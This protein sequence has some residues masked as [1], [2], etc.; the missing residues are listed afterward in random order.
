MKRLCV[1]LACLVFVGINLVQAQTVRITGTVKSSEDGMP[2]PGVSV[3]VKGTTTGAATNIDGVYELNVAANAQTLV[4]SSVGF[5]AQE[6]EIGGRSIIDITLESESLQVEE[7]VVTALGIKRSEKSLPYVSQEVK[8]EELNITSDANIK[9]AIV[10][11]VAGVQI[12]GQ[13]G[14]KLGESGRIRIRGAVSMTAD[15]DPLYVLD[16]VPVSDPNIIDME[17]VASVNVL[18]GPNATA[19]YGQRAE[20]GV[21]MITSKKATKGGIT[22]EVNNN[23]TFD[24]VAYLPNYQN[25]YGQG[26]WGQDEWTTLNFAA[27]APTSPTGPGIYPYPAE[28]SVFD[29]EKYIWNAYADESWGP[30]F[31]GSDYIPWYAIWEDSPYF[32]QTAKWKAQPNNIKNFF[33]VGVTLKN[34]VTIYGSGENYNA[35]VSYTNLN[36]TGTLPYTYLKKHLISSS[37]SYKATDKLTIDGNINYTN[38]LVNGDFDDTYSN[39]TTGSFN[40]WFA[41]DVD[42]SKLRELKDMKTKNGFHASWNHWGMGRIARRGSILNYGYEKP[43]FWYNSYFWMDNFVNKVY[44]NRFVGDLKATYKI[45]EKF[46]AEAGMSSSVSTRR[47]RFELPYIISNSSSPELYNTWNNGFGNHK[48]TS[49]ENNYN[50]RFQFKDKFGDFDV[51]TFIGSNF[52]VNEYDDFTANMAQGSKTQGLV[53]PDVYTYSNTKTPVTPTTSFWQ[54]KVFSLYGNGSVGWKS[55]AFLDL[56]YRKDWSSA[57]PAAKNGYGYPSVGTSFIFSELISDKS[58]LSFGKIRAGWAQVG[59]DLAALDINPTY[60]LSA[61]PYLGNPQM[62]TQN[63]QVDPNIKPALNTSV[64]AGF[65]VNFLNNRVGLNFTYFSETRKDEIIPITISSATGFTSYLTNAGEAKRTGI[66]ITITGTPVKKKNVIWDATLNYGKSNPT[67]ESLPQGLKSMAAPGGSDDWAFIATIHELGAKWGQLRG[68]AVKKDENGNKVVNPDGT[69]VIETG[70]YLGS[71]LPDFTGGLI[72]SVTLYDMVTISAAI[73][74]QKGGKFFS[75][76]EMWG[77]YTGI[78]KE[79]AADNDKGN[80]VRDAVADGGGVHVKGV[81]EDGTPFD[82][83]CEGY[84]YFT[85]F[86]ANVIASQFIHNATYVKLRDVSVSFNVPKKWLKSTFISTASVGFVGRNLWLMYVA[87]DNKHGWD[88]SEMSQS[89]GENAQ[90]PGTRSFGFNVK[91]TF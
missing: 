27:G 88:P 50:A 57:L 12:V 26:Y 6:V 54:K 11:K 77:E 85:Q 79:T 25:K 41:R 3:I 16:G 87:K 89:W 83:Y 20:F 19:L 86:N 49:K 56:S 14:S 67:I 29:G 58:I 75:L 65:D 4:F 55:M 46:S 53:L 52:R 72:N 63:R 17:N 38:Q 91:L 43:A 81:L 44:Q 1:F 80:S 24:K 34:T 82:G 28:W 71:I 45:N 68:T 13:A 78:L 18:K 30:E 9:N 60:P 35:R 36:Q 23:T 15:G 21:V 47:T 32:G 40:A 2:I 48:S 7:L 31:D 10:G 70:Q 8:S 61:S 39:Q 64:E 74:F 22:V 37:V 66:E 51:T 84:D 90:L 76:S 33:D 69:Y 73:D 62:Y 59:N 5:K 42:M